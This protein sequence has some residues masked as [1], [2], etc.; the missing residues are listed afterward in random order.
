MTVVA[1]ESK[2]PRLGD[3]PVPLLV[4]HRGGKIVRCQTMRDADLLAL[5]ALSDDL[6]VVAPPYRPASRA[7]RRV[8]GRLVEIYRDGYTPTTVYDEAL[9]EIDLGLTAERQALAEAGRRML[10]GTTTSASDDGELVIGV[11]AFVPE[12]MR[13]V[14]LQV[15]LS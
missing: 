1:V 9:G 13:A 3:E 12:D 4:E 10:A 11:V 6:I 2:R 7:M 5:L 14:D 8:A 15:A